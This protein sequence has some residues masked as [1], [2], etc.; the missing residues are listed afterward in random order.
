MLHLL[1]SGTALLGFLIAIPLMAMWRT[2]PPNVWLG[3]FLLSISVLAMGEGLDIMNDHATFGLLH[4]PV[5]AYG[6][7]YFMYARS[8]VGRPWRAA[9]IWHA[10]PFVAYCGLLL[11]LH[12]DMIGTVKIG[13]ET[14]SPIFFASYHAAQLL[15]FGYLMAVFLMLHRHR[16]RV[17]EFFSSTASRDL[18]W[19]TWLTVVLTA[20]CVLWIV[21]HQV[22]ER[23]GIPMIFGRVAIMYFVAWFGSRQGAVF[24]V[25]RPVDATVPPAPSPEQV[26]IEAEPAPAPPPPTRGKYARSGMTDA[27]RD[28]IGQRLLRRMQE[29]H[30]YLDSDL[31]LNVLAERIGALP[32]LVSQYLNDVLKTSFFDYVNGYRVAAVERRMVDPATRD[33]TLLDM[34]LASGFSSKSTFNAAFKRV[35]G[36]PPSAWRS[37]RPE[38][39]TSANI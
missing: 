29:H 20:E 35:H 23:A 38:P 36:M 10:V 14:M 27:A 11:V 6:P 28:L 26:P 9:H 17:R 15:C 3:L 4:W 1:I 18:A 5:A 2:R 13:P 33:M 12:L 39:A 32:H 30:D 25:G 22:D 8:V 24:Q 7:L 31:T 34:A 19:L 21:A 16:R 37:A